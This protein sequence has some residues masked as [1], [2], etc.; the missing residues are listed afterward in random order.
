VNVTTSSEREQATDRNR[1]FVSLSGEFSHLICICNALTGSELCRYYDEDFSL[2][3]FSNH[4]FD[5]LR[6]SRTKRSNY[7]EIIV[8][9]T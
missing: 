3:N 7:E 5:Y 4:Y 2:D 6:I 8:S 9:Q 1:K